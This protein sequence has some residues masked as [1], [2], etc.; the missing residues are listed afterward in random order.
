MFKSEFFAGDP[1]EP[2]RQNLMAALQTKKKTEIE[3]AVN[4]L[5][6]QA[7]PKF[8]TD[9]DKEMLARIKKLISN[10]DFKDSMN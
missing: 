2:L 1:N 7:D 6:S 8:L 5:E 10:K 9:D 4:S 3:K